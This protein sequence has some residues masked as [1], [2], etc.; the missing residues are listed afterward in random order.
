MYVSTKKD[1]MYLIKSYNTKE[2]VREE[3]EKI[4]KVL[5]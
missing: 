1:L 4:E 3:K 2:R 5:F